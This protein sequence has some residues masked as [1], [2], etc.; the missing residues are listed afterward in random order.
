MLQATR[1]KLV[2]VLHQPWL[3]RA[4]EHGRSKSNRKDNNGKST[5]MNTKA[6]KTIKTTEITAMENGDQKGRGIKPPHSLTL[7]LGAIYSRGIVP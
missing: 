6:I 1:G 2:M 5:L 3:H 4:P 7:S